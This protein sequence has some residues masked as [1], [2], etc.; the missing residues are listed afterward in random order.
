MVN[1]ILKLCMSKGFLLDKEM[2]ELLSSF[3]EKNVLQVVNILASLGIEERVITKDIF[4]AHSDRFKNILAADKDVGVLLDKD[5]EAEAEEGVGGMGRVKLLSVPSF[6]QRKIEVRDFVNH[7]KFRYDV[8][9]EIL[10]KG[11]YNNLSSIRKIGIAQGS[12]VIIGMVV[13]KRVTK[14][15][16]ILLEVEDSTGKVNVLIN[17][18]RQAVFEKGRNLMLDDVV[19]FRVSGTSDILFVDDLIFPEAGLDTELVSNFDEWVAFSGDFHIGSTMF[20]EEELLRFVKWINGVEG[21]PEQRVIGKKIKYLFLTGDNI[22]G[23]NHYPGQEKFLNEMTSY[24][25]YKK[26]EEIL[27][28]VRDDVEIIMCPGQHDSVWVGE[29]QPM[30]SEKWAPGLHKIPNLHLVPNPSLIEIDGGFKVLMYHGA[31]INRFIDEMSDIRTK[32]GHSEPTRIVEEMLKRRHLAPMHSL[33]DYIPCEKN[34]PMV[35]DIV[36]DIVA[37]AD[38]H[39]AEV[40]KRHN[41]L[42]I[43][44]SCWQ[45]IT[46]FEEKVGNVPIPC[47]V[48]VFNLKNRDVKMFDFSE[49]V[50]EVDVK[51]REGGNEN[52][53]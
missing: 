44:S 15:R 2:L 11:D 52:R 41:I 48:P 5:V 45:S 1:E 17:Q 50:E 25:Q 23:V 51:I 42:M 26:V 22:D 39:R 29:P 46:P 36:P 33:V 43:A 10:A 53:S 4:M 38:Q 6:P 9:N 24:D 13:S 28:L 27:K 16:N 12:Y 30:I 14:N 35:I 31:S 20:L 34:D 19:A 7:F 8:L 18:N 49:G 21:T 3:E 40:A 47:R 37:T 32:F